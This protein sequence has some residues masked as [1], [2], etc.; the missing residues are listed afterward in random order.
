VLQVG[1]LLHGRFVWI[2]PR[3]A[4]AIPVPVRQTDT[5]VCQ[6]E[7][8][9]AVV[10]ALRMPVGRPGATAPRIAATVFWGL[11]RRSGTA[12]GLRTRAG[13]TPLPDRGRGTRLVV[14]RGSRAIGRAT[15]LADGRPVERG[16]D[17][18]PYAGPLATPGRPTKGPPAAVEGMRID[19]VV[20][21]PAS[22][23]PQLLATTAT[24]RGRCWALLSSLV[25]GEPVRVASRLGALM[26][27][28]RWCQETTELPSGRWAQIG[29]SS[30]SQSAQPTAERRRLRERRIMRGTST[31]VLGFPRD[32]VEVDIDGPTGIRTVRTVLVGRVRLAVLLSAGDLPTELFVWA[33]DRRRTYTGRDAAGREVRLRPGTPIAP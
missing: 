9:T 10:G 13:T 28:T 18:Q 20:A 32:V 31:T 27:D 11:S 30:S 14:A 23:R 3:R 24:G 21:D 29:G 6:G 26:P 22:D 16:L 8:R 5:T 17:N 1:R 4:T 33:G 7:G 19:A 2:D 12:V 15:V 25:D